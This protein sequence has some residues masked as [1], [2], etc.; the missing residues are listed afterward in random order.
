[1]ASEVLKPGEI[2]EIAYEFMDLT[3][4]EEFEREL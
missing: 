1:V 4:Q 2:K 3:P